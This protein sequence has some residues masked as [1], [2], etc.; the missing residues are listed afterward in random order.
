[1]NRTLKKLL[2]ALGCVCVIGSSNVYADDIKICIDYN[3]I[4]LTQEAFIE[5]GRVLIPL[6]SVSESLGCIVSWDEVQRQVK[7]EREF[8]NI[9]FTIGDNKVIVNNEIIEIDAKP[10]IVNDR[11]YIPLRALQEALGDEVTWDGETRSVNIIQ[12]DKGYINGEWHKITS[13]V[14]EYKKTVEGSDAYAI[15]KVSVPQIQNPTNI[16]SIDKINEYYKEEGSECFNNFLNQVV[17]DEEIKRCWDLNGVPFGFDLSYEIGYNANDI[18]SIK[19]MLYMNTG[20]VHPNYSIVC[21]VFDT[22]TG[23]K[24]EINDILKGTKE[25][26][27]QFIINGFSR[28]IDEDPDMFFYDAKESLSETIRLVDY[29]LDDGDLV[30]MFDIYVLAPYAAGVQEFRVN[31]KG[32]KELFKMEFID[33]YNYEEENRIIDLASDYF[34]DDAKLVEKI[35]LNNE[36]CYILTNKENKLVAIDKNGELLYNL[37]KDGSMYEITGTKNLINGISNRKALELVMDK[38]NSDEYSYEIGGYLL[39]DGVEYIIVVMQDM[40]EKTSSKVAVNKETG[41]ILTYYFD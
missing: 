36:E 18:L 20:G 23:N 14:K 9:I 26:I 35:T 29:Y 22:N 38:I 10:Q 32:N 24:V 4:K 31:I 27:R 21:D 39:E 12:K 33:V 28:K 5:N 1:M 37:Q 17:D 41:E 3:P 19:R 30:F 15:V 11:T 34:E 16:I 8:K 2:L 25:E 6:R 40:E 13:L 7:I